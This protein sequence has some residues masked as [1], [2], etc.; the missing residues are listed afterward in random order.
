MDDP[1]GVYIKQETSEDIS[2]EINDDIDFDPTNLPLDID[3]NVPLDQEGFEK[4]PWSCDSCSK[5]FRQRNELK[6]HERCH[7][8]ERPY[9]C[10]ICGKGFKYSS[11]FADHMRLHSG[12][13]RYPCSECPKKFNTN[14]NLKTHMLTHT[15]E[16]PFVCQFCS[17]GFT[18]AG[19]L[20][21][22]V[23]KHHKE[24][25]IPEFSIQTDHLTADNEDISNDALSDNMTQKMYSELSSSS[26]EKSFS[27]PVCMMNLTFSYE[28]KAHMKSNHPDARPFICQNCGK[29]FKHKA[30][31]TDHERIHTGERRHQCPECPKKFQTGSNL[32]THMLV[33]TKEL[34][35]LCQFCP[36]AFSTNG[37]LK[38]HSKKYHPDLFAP[39][40]AFDAG[41]MLEQTL[42]ENDAEDFKQEQ[43]DVNQKEISKYESTSNYVEHNNEASLSES[44]DKTYK[45]EFCS[46]EFKDSS[47]FVAHLRIHSGERP[48][49][50]QFCPK[51]F[52]TNSNLKVHMMIHTG[53]SPFIC[54]LCNMGFKTKANLRRHGMTHNNDRPFECRF[55]R[56]TFKE[57]HTLRNH[58]KNL[59][60]M[61]D[62]IN[63]TSDDFV[64]SFHDKMLEASI[65]DEQGKYADFF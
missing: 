54:K 42:E 51:K 43:S 6:I 29:G 38:N 53:E 44:V 37:N 48:Y 52:N 19:N 4:L 65:P 31:L 58:E 17:K 32:K 61:K 9:A 35:F 57:S 45:C 22:H 55:C 21:T 13:K 27:C 47:N 25:F 36:K 3:I 40:I 16:L 14:S 28:L 39:E 10:K 33:H 24:A 2:E 64:D 12:E 50:C 11:N 62:Q 30:N 18:T 56:K 5:S 7:T 23:K 34:P 63:G 60:P 1:S 26:Q 59:C 49:S 8:G 15:K 46:K 20:R 41:P